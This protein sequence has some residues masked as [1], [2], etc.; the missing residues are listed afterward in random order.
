MGLYYLLV[1]EV[2]SMP[3]V[4]A[5]V[6]ALRVAT[7]GWFAPTKNLSR[8]AVMKTLILALISFTS[9]ASYSQTT[10]TWR[11]NT[12]ADFSAG[13]LDSV[14]VTSIADGEVMLRHPLQPEGE[15][16]FDLTQP[17]Y[18]GHDDHGNYLVTT[19]VSSQRIY[20]QLFDVHG[21]PLTDTIRVNSGNR[22][23][24]FN[25]L[26][27]G[28]LLNDGSFMVSW[29][30]KEPISGS[31][32]YI[33]HYFG[34]FFDQHQKK[35]G[36][37][38]QLF[39]ATSSTASAPARQIADQFRRRYLLLQQTGNST[40]G[41]KI[42]GRF[43]SSEGACLV[44]SFQL[45]TTVMKND[46]FSAAAIHRNGFIVTWRSTNT[47]VIP[48]N[49]PCY[50]G[51][52]DTTGLAVNSPI[53]ING[54]SYPAFDTN[55]TCLAIRGSWLTTMTFAIYGQLLDSRGNK[56]SDEIEMMR[57][58]YV[59]HTCT[60][61][62]EVIYVDGHFRINWGCFYGNGTATE[63]W[64]RYWRILNIHSGVYTSPVFDA[65][66][67][68]AQYSTISW[69]AIAS[70]T[71][72][73]KFQLRSATTPESFV[74]AEWSGSTSSS[75]FYIE[76]SGT[77]IRSIHN[78]HRYLQ[79][80]AFLESDTT[81][82]S[83]ILNEVD[84][85]YTV[86][87]VVAPASPSNVHATGG[88]R[89]V[90]IRWNRS[91]TADVKFYRVYRPSNPSWFR[92]VPAQAS[93]YVDS[94]VYYTNA[95]QYAVKA[96]DSSLNES[97]GSVSNVASPVCADIFVST[98]GTFSGDGSLSK[99]F[100]TIT[101][102]I[103]YA[104]AGDTIRVLAG[105]YTETFELRDSVSL[106]GSGPSATRMISTGDLYAL[107]VGTHTVIKGFTFLTGFGIDCAGDSVIITENVLTHQGNGF[108]VAV[109]CESY[110]GIIISKNLIM[111][112]PIGISSLPLLK[113]PVS[114]QVA[115]R[116]NIIRC[117][118]DP[119]ISICVD[120]QGYQMEITN[121]TIMV[122]GTGY[123]VRASFGTT[124]IANNCFVGYPSD[125]PVTNAIGNSGASTVDAQ[126]NNRWRFN[127][128]SDLPLTAT[129]FSSNPQFV[130]EAKYNYHILPGSPCIDAGN[131]ALSSND[132]NG[133]RNDL[134]A[135]GGP[136]PMPEWVTMTLPREISLTGT[137][138]FTG[139]TVSVSVDLSN[140]AGVKSISFDFLFDEDLFKFQSASATPL[141]SGFTVS[142]HSEGYGKAGVVL[143]GAA[144]IASGGGAIAFLRF[145]VG[146]VTHDNASAAIEVGSVQILD[147]DNKPLDVL[148]VKNGTLVGRMLSVHPN[149]IY[150]AAGA[151]DPGN[152]SVKQPY[153]GIQEGIDAAK[154]GDTV[155]VASGD[156][157]G[158][159]TM[160]SGVF[161]LGL[162]ANVVRI[163]V[164]GG[165]ALMPAVAKFQKVTHSGISGFT[166]IN[167]NAT[168]N[169]VLLDS[170]S[171]TVSQN[172]LEQGAGGAEYVLVDRGSTLTLT[173]N[174]FP[175][176]GGGYMQMMTVYSAEVTVARNIFQT[177]CPTTIYL[178]KG[179]SAT[180]SNNSFS[181]PRGTMAAVWAEESPRTSITNNLFVA[182]ASAGLAI[183]F[184]DVKN[185]LVANNVFDGCAGGVEGGSSTG[186]IVNNIFVSSLYGI[187]P[188]PS[189]EHSYN[190]FWNNVTNLAAGSK[191]SNESIADPLFENAPSGLYSLQQLSPARNAGI[192]STEWNDVDGSRNDLGMF[193]GP[194]A[195]SATPAL[196]N[197]S[198]RVGS[199]SGTAGD[200]IS[201][202]IFGIHWKGIAAIHL[203]ISFDASK[204]GL[205]QI[206]TTPSTKNFALSYKRLGNSLVSIDMKADDPTSVDS[207]E[208]VRLV[209]VSSQTA[210]QFAEVSLPAASL[211]DA[212]TRTVGLGCVEG[213]KI[214]F[215]TTRI[216]SSKVET[217]TS[218][219]LYQNYPNPFNPTTVI[220]YEVPSRG[221]I[222]V[223]LYDVLGR[224]V[225]TLL[226]ET[227][228][229][230]R[231]FLTVDAY[232]LSSGVYFYTLR[233]GSY[234]AARKMMLL[235]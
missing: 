111:G 109:R 220:S 35:V 159:L 115:I 191:D 200:T 206:N 58:V 181:M 20:A 162:G 62:I 7:P 16:V 224:E 228:E 185:G 32:Q 21:V 175:E 85:G 158:P 40:S 161:V 10:K 122:E 87:D 67:S 103:A 183:Q 94:S 230:G 135:Y 231:H 207:A 25:G 47:N 212:A 101:S 178:S 199:V 81:G 155:M 78:N 198:L 225:R 36:E 64:Y 41:T 98:G 53:L 108:D 39:E 11:Q 192:P 173:D 188:S 215:I 104:A 168:G 66:D 91:P 146:T 5:Y 79:Y 174:M 27:P 82:D 99:P 75:D 177:V 19:T 13:T 153:P 130:S 235:K 106:V 31:S 22:L 202:P 70:P 51:F 2:T 29:I 102:G 76:A 124:L 210:D 131:P 165:P 139:D 46:L 74:D 232:G 176:S 179:A 3:A 140:A 52:Y 95:Y 23:Y 213:G 154:S 84:I 6:Y 201:L 229:A 234:F 209:F 83:P 120:A 134:G 77:A 121:N 1:D 219:E 26:F 128:L 37:N 226:H 151:T 28:A 150:V 105:D 194:F 205:M 145:I 96:V 197:S 54:S 63:E 186:K 184:K 156:Y 222:T 72:R 216:S 48:S 164:P 180:I 14:V 50:I 68:K 157:T 187:K 69:E 204:L 42:S 9:L 92:D 73:V 88:H 166:L 43:F 126:Y 45:L 195:D 34:Q 149:Y 133:T 17:A 8:E 129:E 193:G 127:G 60:T 38:V 44:D 172:R 227:K 24:T 110:R 148:S 163:E 203:S 33:L 141:T 143:H 211:C 15:E 107:K 169:V 160:K 59:D 112:Y 217:P 142:S 116:N 61:T 208:V 4:G 147:E 12:A 170:S 114:L 144:E 189:T 125:Q 221:M 18:T 100:R 123:G 152:G 71:R 117:G 90:T 97:E 57:K 171:A 214:S 56:L 132:V 30:E 223:I 137:A 218:F 190:M 86:T 138:G 80:R 233:T 113:G 118:P 89:D 119:H 49:A 182:T 55:G 167:N 65:G 93:V 136:D 196:F